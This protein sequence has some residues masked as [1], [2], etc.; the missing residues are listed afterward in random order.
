[1]RGFAP[2]AQ[3]CNV[4]PVYRLEMEAA[5]QRIFSTFPGGSPGLGLLL[6]RIMVGGTAATLGTQYFS[7][8]IDRTPI[9][10]TLAV[11]LILGGT[12][13]VIGFLTPF[14]SLAVGLCV[15]GIT[16]SWF[17]APPLNGLG[18]RFLAFVVVTTAVGIALLGPGAFSLDGYLFGRREIVIPPRP[19]ES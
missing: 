12:S 11:I 2:V 18:M 17:P 5:L 3:F 9:I 7:D 16:I 1:M 19:P 13:I 6:L 15:F 8:T 10:W 4:W 14:A